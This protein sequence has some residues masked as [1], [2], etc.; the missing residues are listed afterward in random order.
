MILVVN[1]PP[2]TKIAGIAKEYRWLD[3]I[4]MRSKGRSDDHY[5][6]EPKAWNDPT[7]DGINMIVNDF[8]VVSD[9]PKTL[10]D[11]CIDMGFRP[12]T[13]EVMYAKL[14]RTYQMIFSAMEELNEDE[15]DVLFPTP[16]GCPLGQGSIFI[17]MHGVLSEQYDIIDKAPVVDNGDVIAIRYTVRK[18]DEEDAIGD[19]LASSGSDNGQD[20][21][22]G[23]DVGT[24][25]SQVQ[26][27]PDLPAGDNR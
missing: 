5:L 1:A 18:K 17:T 6:I 13:T 21:P 27:S 15:I 8:V 12:T 23:S 19:T 22:D 16:Q 7:Y 3:K 10:Y 11:R 9:M 2:I 24:G 14:D 25:G 26:E 20:V 4:I